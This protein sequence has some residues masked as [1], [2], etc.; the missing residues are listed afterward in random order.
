MRFRDLIE[1][2]LGIIGLVLW[3]GLTVAMCA[4]VLTVVKMAEA[5]LAG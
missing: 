4:G 2:G 5:W 3:V 1:G